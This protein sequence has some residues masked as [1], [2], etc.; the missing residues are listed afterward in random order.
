MSTEMTTTPALARATGELW[1]RT[2]GRR[3]ISP[4]PG[5]ADAARAVVSAA[6]HDPD[7]DVI[8]RTLRE[9]R[10]SRW[11]SFTNDAEILRCCGTDF[12]NATRRLKRGDDGGA[13]EAFADHLADAVRAAIL[14]ARGNGGA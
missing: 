12:G 1:D 8:A 2:G 3:E 14:G 6:L 11:S 5:W 4:P 7:D 9:H 10:P 13:W